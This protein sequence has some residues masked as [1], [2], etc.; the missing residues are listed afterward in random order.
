[1][2]VG[3]RMS[4][5]VMLSALLVLPLTVAAAEDPGVADIVKTRQHKLKDIVG[6]DAKDISDQLKSSS[7]DQKVIQSDAAEIDA[8]LKDL[9]T[10][11]PKGSGPEAGVKTAA[12]PEIWQQADDFHKA[13]DNAQGAADKFV[14]VAATGD[15][16]AETSAFMSLGMS[17]GGCHK[18]F[19]VKDQ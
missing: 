3:C 11:F 1:M 8:T 6:K 10:W 13:Y 16:K 5:W 17:C 7:P 14:Q 2:R 4:G 15:A 19:R 18:P 9:P 12:K